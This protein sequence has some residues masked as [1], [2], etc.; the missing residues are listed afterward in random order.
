VQPDDRAPETAA[1][2]DD[3]SY[4]F[5]LEGGYFYELADDQE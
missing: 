2:V 3:F 5:Y 4:H 1:P